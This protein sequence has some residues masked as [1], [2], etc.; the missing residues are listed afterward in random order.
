[1]RYKLIFHLLLFLFLH[2]SLSTIA[3]QENRLSVRQAVELALKNAIDL[4]NLRID[5]LKQKALNRQITGLSLP[6]ISASGQ[7]AHYLT[8][9]KVL[10]PSTGESSIYD[11]LNREGV[12]DGSGNVI[13]PK[14]DFQ[15]QEFSFV[16]PWSVSSGIGMN[17]LLFQPEVFVGLLARNTL[18]EFAGNNITV[19]E[20]KVREQVEKAYYQVLIAQKQLTVLKQTIQRIEKLYADQEQLY[21]NGF[22]ERLDLD[23]TT[24]TLNNTRSAET[25]LANIIELGMAALK[26]SMGI[27]Q[28]ET[29]SLTDELSDDLVKEQLPDDEKV[30]YT[31]RSEFKLLQTAQKLGAI[32]VRRYKLG[33]IPTLAFFYQ[34]QQQGQQN[35]NFSSF[36]GKNWF[37]FNSN[38]IGL[39]MNVTLFDGMQRKN[40]MLQAQYELEKTRNKTTQF[41]QAVDLEFTV[42]KT[43]LRNAILN[44]DAQKKNMELAEKVFQTSRKKY[45]QGLG[46]TFEVLLSD[47]EWQRAQGSYFESLYNAVQA[48]INYR[49]ATGRL[50]EY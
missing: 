13:Q 21:K 40:K 24:V 45:E 16:Q 7:V 5:S 3:Q 37:W 33:G 43:N 14:F 23:K 46:S 47:T 6:Q 17:Q 30:D 38:L 10:F 36:T 32:D 27:S 15:V 20:D 4:K 12:K 50:A 42:A 28:S 18:M 11:V 22:I 44:M 8:L 9:P 48:K 19:A 25:Q 34:F 2:S 29:I 39:S 26:F 49:K 31:K 1:M 41:Q 35:R